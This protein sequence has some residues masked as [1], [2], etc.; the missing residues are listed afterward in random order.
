MRIL[1][2]IAQILAS[3]PYSALVAFLIMFLI[4]AAPYSIIFIFGKLGFF[5]CILLGSLI[6][7]LIATIFQF[8]TMAVFIPYIWITK[9]NLVATILSIITFIV[10]TIREIIQFWG[11][12]YEHEWETTLLCIIFTIVYFGAMVY[13]SFGVLG[14][15]RGNT[16]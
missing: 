15:N 3:V 13:V 8:A 10:M 4:C 2:Y 9:E 12:V 11:H 1:N 14:S 16:D 6:L 5:W 7:A